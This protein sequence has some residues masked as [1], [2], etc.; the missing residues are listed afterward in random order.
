MNAK[1]SGDS[2][3]EA[4]V[5]AAGGLLSKLW[6]AWGT[7]GPD[8]TRT[9]NDVLRHKAGVACIDTLLSRILGGN[10]PEEQ[11]QAR[12]IWLRTLLGALAEPQA[13]A[14]GRGRRG[15]ANT[16]ATHLRAA[17][18]ALDAIDNRKLAVALL[19]LARVVEARAFDSTLHV[20]M[21]TENFVPGMPIMVHYDNIRRSVHHTRARGPSVHRGDIVRMLASGLR[22]PPPDALAEVMFAAGHHMNASDVRQALGQHADKQKAKASADKAAD[23]AL[24]A[25]RK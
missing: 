15:L 22:E 8:R 16:A 24:R 3:R 14:G 12:M 7:L 10:T 5:T 19:D 11:A 6:S 1:T 2:T 23:K 25:W 18:K 21:D 9:V 13:D 17:C 20:R 4:I